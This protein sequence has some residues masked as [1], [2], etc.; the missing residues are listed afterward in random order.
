MIDAH[1][2]KFVQWFASLAPAE[3][4]ETALI[5]R[6]VPR[7][8]DKGQIQVHADGAIKATWPSFLPSRSPRKGEAWYG[9]TASFISERFMDG[10]PSA[11]AAAC[12]YVLVMVLDD[13]GT[14]SQ[15]PPLPPTWVMETSEGN[16]QWGYAFSE[17]PPKADFAAAITAIAAAGYTDPGACNPVRNFR[18]PGSINLKPGRNGFASRLVEFHPDREFTLA[19]VCAALGVTPGPTD[20][21]GPRPLRLADDG[22]DDVV[23]WLSDQGMVYSRP[24]SEGWMGVHCP[25]ADQHTD[26]S[27]EG[28]YLP[29]GRAFCCLHSHC[30]DLD[31][32]RFLD[33]VASQGG[34]SRR[35]GLR[36]ELLSAALGGALAHLVPTPALAAEAAAVVAEVER[37]EAGRLAQ[38]EWFT[39]YAYVE[40]DDSFF[41][42]IERRE[43]SRRVFDAVYRHVPCFSVHL[44][45]A[46]K[47]RQIPA[48]YYFDEN[49]IAC[50]ARSVAGMTYAAG[51]DM[52]VSRSG[53]VFVNRWRDARPAA[54]ASSVVPLPWL[55]HLE[56]VIP[57]R[58]ER[59]HV[60]NVMAWKVQHPRVKIN[61]AILHAGVQGAGK[62]SAWAPFFWAVG[63]ESRSNVALLENDRLQTQWGYHLEAE[64]VVI[65]ELRQADASD[66]RGLENRLKSIIAAPPEHLVIE[67]KGL[68]PY[69]APN[70]C[71]VVAFSN[72]RGAISLSY[73]DRR[74]FVLW[75]DAAPMTEAEGRAFWGWLQGGGFEQCA[76]YLHARDVTAFAPGAPPPLTEAKTLMAGAS[77]SIVEDW[78][79]SEVSNRVGEFARPVV[80]A[81][82]GKLCDLVQARAPAGTRVIPAAVIHALQ[83]ARWVDLGLCHSKTYKTKAHIFAAPGWT[84][85][86]AEAR[87][88]LAAGAAGGLSLVK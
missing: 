44:T 1:Y 9:N 13:I 59:E 88:A 63:G 62:D 65:N 8:D 77:R 27:P 67:R 57:N 43:L 24:N 41:D 28:R 86:K 49:R 11:S 12:E 30:L 25:Q 21:G 78:L 20:G 40:A 18:L 22:G 7:L 83:E 14:K 50:G 46:G 87:D 58:L 70:R 79:L 33:W 10:K 56:R 73:D 39:R 76:A 84:G 85:S 48:S 29:S 75:T 69:E 36:E 54:P 60:L 23:A 53:S 17:Q 52:L 74:W 38:K 32:Q 45:Q 51:D 47:R 66:R 3:D 34:P 80:G 61:H 68:H 26:G 72:E 31:S 81:P 16:Y 15:Q 55:A 2:T 19:E 82:W 5:V 6:Q 37:K 4:G 64:V 42:L 35:P 71:S